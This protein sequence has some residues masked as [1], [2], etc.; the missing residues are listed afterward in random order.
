VTSRRVV[1]RPE[2]RTEL[3]DAQT[4]YEDRV[5]GLGRQFSLAVDAAV[6]AILRYPEAGPV[7][8][9]SYR[10]CVLRRFPYSLVYRLDG[11]DVVV[12]AV[13]HQRRDPERWRGRTPPIAR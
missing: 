11:P 2:A 8:H 4:W 3:L 7:V 6:S 13:H 1:F 5:P 9:E 10:Q 12:M